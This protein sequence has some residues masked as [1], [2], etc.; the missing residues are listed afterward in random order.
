MRIADEAHSRDA[1][2]RRL[3]QF[4]FVRP[5]RF[6]LCHF[7]RHDQKG[8]KFLTLFRRHGLEFQPSGG[9]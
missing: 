9:D 5:A 6:H 3:L 8:G 7:P 1:I 4:E 2:A